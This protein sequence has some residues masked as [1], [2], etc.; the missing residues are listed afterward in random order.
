VA[1]GCATKASRGI[2]REKKNRAAEGFWRMLWLLA[3][4]SVAG[5]NCGGGQRPWRVSR[6]VDGTPIESDD[7]N[8]RGGKQ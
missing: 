3:S 6:L 2:G 4:L 8:E 5:D 1:G 7:S